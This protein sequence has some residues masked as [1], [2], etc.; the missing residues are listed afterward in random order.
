[1]RFKLRQAVTARHATLQ[2]HTLFTRQAGSSI[3]CPLVDFTGGFNK[4]YAAAF[5]LEPTA[6]AIAAKYGRAFNPFENDET[7]VVSTLALEELGA[8]G[9]KARISL[10]GSSILQ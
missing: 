6:N 7:F 3:P 8:T 5:G 4:F 2:G 10:Q 1:M 9:N